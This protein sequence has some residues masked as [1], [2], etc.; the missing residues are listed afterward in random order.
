MLNYWYLTWCAKRFCTFHARLIKALF[1]YVSLQNQQS[2]RFIALE[3]DY[4]LGAQFYR[5][6]RVI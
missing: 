2:V 5:N 1:G 4:P 6:V 3:L